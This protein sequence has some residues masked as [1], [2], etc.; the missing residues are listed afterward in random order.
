VSAVKPW[1][2]NAVRIDYN[3]ADSL[4]EQKQL[5]CFFCKTEQHEEGL[6][7]SPALNSQDVSVCVS[8]SVCLPVCLPAW[9]PVS[10]CLPACLEALLQCVASIA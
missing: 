7:L 9:L 5:L 3:S 8:L 6:C 1:L 10:V 2:R 4:L